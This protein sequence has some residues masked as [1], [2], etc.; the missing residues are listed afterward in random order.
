MISSVDTNVLVALWDPGDALN[1]QALSALET[2]HAKGG[3]I[4]CGAVYAEL[5]AL[6]GRSEDFLD[7]FLYDTGIEVDWNSSEST[8]RAAGLAFQKYSSRRRKQKIGGPR[9]ILADFFIGSHTFENGYSL[10]TLDHRIY[11]ATFP[12]LCI[13]RV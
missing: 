12:E 4:I 2:A 11:K 8:W 13:I 1:L 10:L 5:L 9:R 7:S 6:P 3:L